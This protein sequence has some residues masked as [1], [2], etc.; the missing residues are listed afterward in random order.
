VPEFSVNPAYR[1]VANQ[2]EARAQLAAAME[3]SAG[4]D[5]AVRTP[6]LLLPGTGASAKDNFS[7]NY[8]PALD[9]RRI[10]W[11][12]ITFPYVGNGD[13]Q[14]NGEY[15]VYAIRTMY[16]RA[17]RPIAIVGHSQG[18][19]V[20][21]WALRFWPDT[22]AMV[23]DVI[24]FAPSNHGTTQT[25][26]SCRDSC[27]VSS[28][29]QAYMSNFIRVLNSFHE[30]FP[31]ISYTNVYTHNDEIVRPNADDTGSSSLHTGDGRIANVATVI[32][33]AVNADGHREILGLEVL[34]SED[35]A[36]WTAFLR[37]LVARGLSGV[38]LVISDD[39]QGLVE[40]I[41][42]VLPG[43]SWQ[44]CRT[45][46]MRNALCLVPKGTQQ[47][48]AATIRTVFV[49]PDAA[50]ARE[51]WRRVADQLRARFPRV[52]QLLDDAEDEVL[53]YLAFPQEHWRQ[54]WSNNP[55]ERLNKEVKRRT[56][57]VGIFPND[58]AV[59]RLVGAIL[60]EQNDEW[61]I[62]RRYFSAESLAKL[63]PPM[64][65]DLLP[66]PSLVEAA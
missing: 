58:R 10:P 48:V 47:M 7:W 27:L 53:A 50:T 64:I 66:T 13:I 28:W 34:T 15:M 2:P 52:A 25:Q 36:G 33:T 61:Q 32:A 21:R 3:C 20:P 38:R 29:Q 56:D 19:M 8:E 60:A 6:V 35:G 62:A 45:H 37:D 51:Q 43:A 30:T 9:A 4:V 1:P 18:G 24:G 63:S 5:H 42:A 14:V 46:F 41:G 22:R 12:A 40:A 55:Q 44:R 11:C 39:H 49:Q 57:V 59:I 65:S 54:I 31:G 16:A 17:G 26:L 23:D